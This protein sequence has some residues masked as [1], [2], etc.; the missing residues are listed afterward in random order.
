MARSDK[1]TPLKKQEFYSDFLINFDT[2]PITGVL[3]RSTNEDSIKQALKNLLLTNFTER[4]YEPLV[5]SRINALL[6]EPFSIITELSLKTEIENSIK[7]NEPR[8]I[9]HDVSVSAKE[10]ENGY[11]INIVFSTINIPQTTQ[12]ELFLQRVR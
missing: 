9:I 1:Y 4:F 11:L 7:N 8:V 5:G 12:L 2:N 6:F 3:A 10:D